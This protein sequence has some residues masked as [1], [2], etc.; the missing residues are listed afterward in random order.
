MPTIEP[1]TQDFLKEDIDPTLTRI[2]LALLEPMAEKHFALEPRE[3]NGSQMG[4]IG[5]LAAMLGTNFNAQKAFEDGFNQIANMTNMDMLGDYRVDQLKDEPNCYPKEC[6]KY[7][8]DPYHELTE[9]IAHCMSNYKVVSGGGYFYPYDGFTGWH[10]NHNN[11]CERLFVTYVKETNKS[12]FKYIDRIT[13]LSV[14]DWD[15][16]PI[17]IRRFKCTAE[18]PYFW[19]S[20]GS[21]TER[22]SYGFWLYEKEL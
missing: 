4:N 9:V 7:D 10:T 15:D 6:R 17:T 19:H 16:S 21:L 12:F 18:A 2:L 1:L 14:T 22:L 13:G 3:E 8:V 20:I 11:P 5:A